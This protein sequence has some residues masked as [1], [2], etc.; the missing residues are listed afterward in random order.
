MRVCVKCECPVVAS[1][2]GRISQKCPGCGSPWT[3]SNAHTAARPDPESFVLLNTSAWRLI[4]YWDE[5]DE[6]PRIGVETS[7]GRDL[8]GAVQWRHE[9][10]T[11][12]QDMIHERVAR[13][14][15][16]GHGHVEGSRTLPGWTHA[17][18]APESA[19]EE[20]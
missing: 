5:E 20:S 11:H 18:W 8:L 19:S 10:T 3:S 13:M 17:L 2:A 6:R 15:H 4:V 7:T 16:E 12:V 14:I 9:E 1:R